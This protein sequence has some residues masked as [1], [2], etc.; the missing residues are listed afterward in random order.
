MK[1]K[2]VL[3]EVGNPDDDELERQ[4]RITKSFLN[5]LYPGPRKDMNKS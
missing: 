2:D 5:F 3:A 4:E 1:I